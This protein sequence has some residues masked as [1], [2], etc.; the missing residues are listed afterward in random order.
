MEQR[1]NCCQILSSAFLQ[2]ADAEDLGRVYESESKLLEP[3]TDSPGE[4]SMDDWWDYLGFRE[5]ALL[6]R[7][8]GDRLLIVLGTKERLSI[9]SKTNSFDTDMIGRRW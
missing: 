9:T 8:L 6:F 7:M 2:G 5:Y 3:W 1:A 4:I